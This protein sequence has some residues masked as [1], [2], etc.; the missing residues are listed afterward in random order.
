MYVI[1]ILAEEGPNTELAWLLYL[2]LGFFLLIIIVGWLTSRRSAE[3]AEAGHESR[4]HSIA[5]QPDDL[6]VIEGIGPKVAKALKEAGIH[7][8]ADLAKANAASVQKILDAAGLQ[9][10][11]PEGWIEQ[12]KLAAKGDMDGLK[13]LQSEMKGGR[14]K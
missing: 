5:I 10:L 1:N 8:F 6:T 13:K 14:I 9:M 3:Q 11:N 7:S 12:A 4:V 2:A